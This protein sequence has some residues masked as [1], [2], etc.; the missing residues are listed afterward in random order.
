MLPGAIPAPPAPGQASVPMIQPA[1]KKPAV[2]RYNPETGKIEEV[3]FSPT[4]SGLKDHPI[5]SLPERMPQR[6]GP[7]MAPA[8][9]QLQPEISRPSENIEHDQKATETARGFVSF[10]ASLKAHPHP[11]GDPIWKFYDQAA[12]NDLKKEMAAGHLPSEFVVKA[13]TEYNRLRPDA[14]IDINRFMAI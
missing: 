13:L 9:E 5:K 7:Q 1:V 8:Q 4:A 6:P 2:R 14:P 11:A 10:L 3:G 12:L